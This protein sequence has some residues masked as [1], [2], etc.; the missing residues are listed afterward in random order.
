MKNPTCCFFA[1]NCTNFH[2]LNLRGLLNLREN[3]TLADLA[4][5]GDKNLFNPFNLW[6]KKTD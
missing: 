6:Q 1:T 2:K 5:S 4:D 3:F